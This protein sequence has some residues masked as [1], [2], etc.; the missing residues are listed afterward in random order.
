M[1]PVVSSAGVVSAGPSPVAVVDAAV[2]GLWGAVLIISGLGVQPEVASVQ[3]VSSPVSLC[4][5]YV[6][7]SDSGTVTMARKVSHD[8]TGFLIRVIEPSSQVLATGTN[9]VTV[10]VA[11]TVVMRPPVAV[12]LLVLDARTWSKV[13]PTHAPG[14]YPG[15]GVVRVVAGQPAQ[16]E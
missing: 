4:L 14:M 15:T 9:F 1:A 11:V 5:V 12:E 16:K 6:V 13:Q 2:H 7:H 8:S 10:A 3:V